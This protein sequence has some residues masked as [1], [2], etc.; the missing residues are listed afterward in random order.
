MMGLRPPYPS[1]LKFPKAAFGPS[2][3][4]TIDKTDGDIHGQRSTGRDLDRSETRFQHL[5]MGDI[6]GHAKTVL[7]VDMYGAGG[8]PSACDDDQLPHRGSALEKLADCHLAACRIGAHV[9]ISFKHIIS[10]GNSLTRAR[11]RH[12]IRVVKRPTGNLSCPVYYKQPHRIRIPLNTCSLR[13]AGT[14]P[15]VA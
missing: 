4:L 12:C 6:G 13:A 15:T 2:P 5:P 8:P 1:I 7:T 10:S 3:L 14:P 9:G 11:T